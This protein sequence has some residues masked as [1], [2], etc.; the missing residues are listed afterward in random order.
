MTVDLS[1]VKDLE[2]RSFWVILVGPQSKDK[3]PYKEEKKTHPQRTNPREDKGRDYSDAAASQGTLGATGNW[4]RR[5]RILPKPSWAKN[6]GH[7][8]ALL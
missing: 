6:Y 1:S 7:T 2:M 8:Y 3:C 4:K 5:G